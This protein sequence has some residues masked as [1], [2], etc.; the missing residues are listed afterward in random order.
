MLPVTATSKEGRERHTKELP[1]GLES[2]LPANPHRSP[3]G[4]QGD[5]A[6]SLSRKPGEICWQNGDW[7]MRPQS[8]GLLTL[9]SV[10]SSRA[11]S[12]LQ[13]G[14][15]KELQISPAKIRPGTTAQI[16]DPAGPRTPLVTVKIF[17]LNSG[18]DVK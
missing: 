4:E 2:A 12:L 8:Q 11:L 17:L 18:L 3:A 7:V 9:K 15:Q 16:L 6:L 1:T 13:S 10:F 14:K 5:G